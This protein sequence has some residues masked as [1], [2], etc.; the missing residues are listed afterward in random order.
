MISPADLWFAAVHDFNETLS[1]ART[2]PPL[3]LG[4]LLLPCVLAVLSR[5]VTAFL[6]T[7]LLA[8]IG[9]PA[10]RSSLED[11][12]RW[13]APAVIILT[14]LIGVALA[15]MFRQA[16]QRLRNA[17]SQLVEVQREL[18]DLSAKHESEVRWRKA[19]EVRKT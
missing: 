15:Y 18:R 7:A 12:N 11:P 17:E 8:I 5:S 3:A 9:V 19:A 4:I 13:L 14:A 1:I 2:L 16:R 10:M 6:L